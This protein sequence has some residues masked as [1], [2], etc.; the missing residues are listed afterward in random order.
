MATNSIEK[1]LFLV[2][3]GVQDT[4]EMEI[5]VELVDDDGTPLDPENEAAEVEIEHGDAAPA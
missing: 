5:E 1:S 2:P 3:Q 4:P